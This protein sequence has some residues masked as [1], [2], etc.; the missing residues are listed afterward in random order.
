VAQLNSYNYYNDP[1]YYTASNYRYSYGGRDYTTNQYGASLLRQAV[2]YGYQ[3]GYEAGIADRDDRWN[4]S[5][6]DSF[7]Y[8]DANYGYNG[9]Y[10]NQSEYNYYFR[11]GFQRG[12]EDSYYGRNQYGAYQNGRASILGNVLSA[13]LNLVET[14]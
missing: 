14:N 2:D 4:Y 8:Q 6:R 12:Y 13:I 3:Q 11:Q 10:V 9:Q 5:Y 1:Y 7:A